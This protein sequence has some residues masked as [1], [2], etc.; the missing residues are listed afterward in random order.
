MQKENFVEIAAVGKESEPPVGEEFLQ[1][2]QKLDE[3]PDI[4]WN[5]KMVKGMAAA[6]E[7]WDLVGQKIRNPG[8]PSEELTARIQNDEIQKKTLAVLD[9]L[10]PRPEKQ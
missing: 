3:S 6:G 7:V 4:S 2:I 1:L 8:L 10:F 5:G 9:R